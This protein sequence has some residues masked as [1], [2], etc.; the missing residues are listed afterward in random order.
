KVTTLKELQ[1]KEDDPNQDIGRFVDFSF[2]KAIPEKK[3]HTIND[4]ESF[5]IEIDFNDPEKSLKK[6]E[7]ITLNV[8]KECPVAKDFGVS[9]TGEGVVW[10]HRNED[11]KELRFKVKGDEHTKGGSKKERKKREIVTIAP[12]VVKNIQEF[13]EITVTNGRLEQGIKEVFPNNESLNRKKL[14]QFI[15]WVQSDIQKEETDVLIA[16]NLEIKQVLGEISSKTR[17]F[18]FECEKTF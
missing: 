1:A 12:E 5:E 9:G 2:I 4:Y 16:N 3:V 10:I 14:G 18:F 17:D 15:K 7:E 11:G 6:L 13:I 8:E